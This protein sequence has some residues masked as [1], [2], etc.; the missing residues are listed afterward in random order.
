MR[1]PARP[2]RATTPCGGSPVSGETE[3][4]TSAHTVDT[5]LAL[6]YQRFS[7]L[8]RLL[9]ERHGNSQRALD[10]AL[11]TAQRE[12]ARTNSEVKTRFDS[13]NE[14]REQLRE[15]A[16]TFMTRLE[17]EAAHRE[18]RSLLDALDKRITDVKESVIENR[19]QDK[20]AG[21]QAAQRR[22]SITLVIGV[23]AVILTAL[24]IAVGLILTLNG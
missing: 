5:A 20:G 16:A 3:K 1:S 19:G 21:E 9:N 17:S 14:F 12:I 23:T 11:D 15:Q 8:D 22:A 7:D 6:V 24:S 10:A 18:L 4:D 2:G 13:V